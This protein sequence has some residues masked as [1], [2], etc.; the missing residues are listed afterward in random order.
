MTTATL[1]TTEISI[2]KMGQLGEG[3]YFDADDTER[4]HPVFVPYT[5]P[6]ERVLVEREGAR[7]KPLEI[8]IPSQERIAPLCKYFGT[9]GGC[10]VQHWQEDKYRAWKRGLIAT[11]LSFENIETQ[12]DEM[13][14]AHGE[15]RR[16]VNFHVRFV[17]GQ[18]LAGFMIART[19]RLVNLDTCPILVPELAASPEYARQIAKPMMRLRKPLD[20]QFTATRSGL[21][22]DIRGAGKIDFEMRMALTDLANS[23][24]L[25]RLSIHGETLLERRIPVLQFGR[26]N[27]PIPA[28]G[29]AQATVLG[30]ETL[31]KLVQDEV[32]DAKR[33]A[34]LF[35][36][37]GPFALRL[38][39]KANVYAADSYA[40]GIQSLRRG[41]NLVQG[42]KQIEAED[43]DLFRRPLITAELKRFEAVVFDPPRAGAEAQAH[44][45]AASIVPVV[46]AVS[47]NVASFSRDAAIL[48][49]GGYRLEKVTP[50][51][52]F[53]HSTHLEMVG[54]FRR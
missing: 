32:G 3:V 31:A 19:H 47:C 33:V 52:Q 37:A 41:A 5:L 44:Q 16:R 29:F 27:V 20:M 51:D 11:A 54:V 53:R 18:P 23:F 45:L 49:A 39:E 21:D 25:A 22:V 24:D 30:E 46:V 9:C 35:C 8:L 36:G 40:A 6:G 10:A 1:N 43:R 7:A 42:L 38:A 13:I 48:V 4:R 50:V 26:V 28:G 2:E 15:G 34:D 12:I 17:E 14:D